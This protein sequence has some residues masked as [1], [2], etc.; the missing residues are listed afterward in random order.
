MTVLL[1]NYV[2]ETNMLHSLHKPAFQV[3]YVGKQPN[4]FV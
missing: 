1:F 2:L 4:K 3:T